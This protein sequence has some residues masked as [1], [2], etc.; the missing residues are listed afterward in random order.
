MNSASNNTAPGG[1][2]HIGTAVVAHGGP[3]HHLDQLP[4]TGADLMVYLAL[5]LAM[6]LAG[7]ILRRLPAR[8]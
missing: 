8:G 7:L 6:I 3:H 5:G 1:G 4:F 2:I